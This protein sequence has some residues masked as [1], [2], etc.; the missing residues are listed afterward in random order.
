MREIK[1]RG[2]SN[3]FEN[4]LVGSLT[5]AICGPMI[6]DKLTSEHVSVVPESVGQLV[7]SFRNGDE[8]Y[9]GDIVECTD[10]EGNKYV[11]VIKWCGG[12]YPAYDLK[13]IDVS[14]TNQIWYFI[15]YGDI[16]VIG[17]TYKNP[18]LLKL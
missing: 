17:N 18:D 12:D 15:Q 16:K 9:E 7:L 6:Y 1:F 5:Q 8:L 3:Y 11:D 4:W 13:N 2:W 10:D 14:D